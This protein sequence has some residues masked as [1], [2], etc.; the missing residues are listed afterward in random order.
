[1]IS[2]DVVANTAKNFRLRTFSALHKLTGVLLR[3]SS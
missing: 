1:M 3:F 2:N